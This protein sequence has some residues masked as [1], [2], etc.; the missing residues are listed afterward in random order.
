[1]WYSCPGR[2]TITMTPVDAAMSITTTKRANAAVAMTIIMS[3][4][5]AAAAMTTIM[6]TGSAAVAMTTIMSRLAAHVGMITTN[7]T[8]NMVTMMESRLFWAQRCLQRA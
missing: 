6:S 1:M 2:N 5:S 3:M 8:M 7:T 4:G